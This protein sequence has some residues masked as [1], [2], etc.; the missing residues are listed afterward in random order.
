MVLVEVRSGNG[1]SAGPGGGSLAVVWQKDVYVCVRVVY[2]C[3]CVCVVCVC[4]CV[5]NSF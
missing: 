1:G 3:V 4:V 2:V 5:E